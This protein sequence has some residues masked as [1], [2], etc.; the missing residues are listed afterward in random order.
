MNFP[1]FL[2]VTLLMDKEFKLLIYF[3]NYYMLTVLC[4]LLMKITYMCFN[5]DP[6]LL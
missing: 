5:Y 4:L 2:L 6:I 3:C 1:K